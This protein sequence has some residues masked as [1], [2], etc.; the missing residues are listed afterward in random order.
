[1]VP[2]TIISGFLGAGKTTL[3]NHL[4]HNPGDDRLA[5]LVNDFGAVNIDQDLI[6]V[7]TQNRIELSNGCVCCSIQDD[8][9]AGLV[10]LSRLP[11]KFTRV[12]LECS[13]VSHPAG[14]LKI[15]DSDPVRE[16]FYVDG[17]FCLIDTSNLL[18]LDFRSAELAIDQAAMSDLVFLNKT[19]LVSEAVR[20]EVR[21]TLQAAQRS[22][23]LLEVL[24]AEIPTAILFGPPEEPKRSR[25]R[26]A[27][28]DNHSDLY[29][30]ASFFWQ[31][32]VNAAAF[33]RF[34]DELPSQIL[35]GKGVLS[36]MVNGEHPLRALFQLVGKRS[37]VEVET[38]DGPEI[39]RIVL[40]ARRGELD[41][42][43]IAAALKLCPGARS[44]VPI[45]R[46]RG[47]KGP[48]I[49]Q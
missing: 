41:R 6:K 32:P 20:V 36:L 1:M 30:S 16:L 35:R 13:G 12:A 15:F 3:I 42:R 49:C 44:F 9:A 43:A 25:Q 33:K 14:I 27:P 31:S 17:L 26:A 24:R 2:A 45:A 47:P 34:C 38:A 18:D 28:E 4:L 19:D 46:P 7:E 21:Q 22:M 10:S 37:S 39:S 8:L 23:K 5:V 11:N 48:M 29:E 40:I